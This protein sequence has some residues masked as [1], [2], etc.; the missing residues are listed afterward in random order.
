MK[1]SLRFVLIIGVLLM[2]AVVPSTAQEEEYFPTTEWRT[3][4]PEEQGMDSVALAEFINN[5][6]LFGNLD[7]MMIVRNGYVVAE[8][9]WHPHTKDLRHEQ[10]SVSKSILSA[11]VGIALEQGHLESLDQKLL[12]FFPEYEVQNLDERKQAIT[13]RDL[14]TMMHGFRCDITTGSDPLDQIIPHE[15]ATQ[16]VLDWAMVDEPDTRWRYCQIN[17]YLL[18]VIISRVTG[19]DTLEF[20]ETTLFEPL[21]ITNVEWNRSAEGMP[22]GF[23]GLELTTVDMAKIGYLYLNNGRWGNEQIVPEEWVIAS[24]QSYA[25]PSWSRYTDYGY[26]WWIYSIPEGKFYEAQGAL[27]QRIEVSVEKNMVVVMTGSDN[28][29]NSGNIGIPSMMQSILRSASAD[30]PLP[31]NTEGVAQLAAAVEAAAQPVPGAID[32]RP[33][34]AAEVSGNTYSLVTTD[35]FLSATDYLRIPDEE[36]Q[37]STFGLDFEDQLAMLRLTTQG[38]T[39]LEI[40]CGLDGVYQV[41]ATHMGAVGCKGRWRNEG[42]F[43]LDLYRLEPGHELQYRLTFEADGFYARISVPSGALFPWHPVSKR[44]EGTLIR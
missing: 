29:L 8:V 4:T 19:Q 24:T 22:L 11:L 1:G 16:F 14:L 21:G 31:A 27:F 35:L 28:S 34:A 25:Q 41:T 15:N 26:L 38:G 33:P 42:M 39:E 2:L 5:V 44:I 3:S 20:A 17:P 10:Y 40:P 23:T 30:E 13:L 9:Y 43:I 37:M 32:P 18:S 36:W 7:S 6:M 12:D